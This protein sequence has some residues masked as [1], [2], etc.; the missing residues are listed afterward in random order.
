MFYGFEQILIEL[1]MA[2]RSVKPLHIRILL[3]LA[4]LDV[5]Q[6]DAV[7]VRPFHHLAADVLRAV[8]TAND[9]GSSSPFHDALVPG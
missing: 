2:C 9:F 7:F 4:G 5:V 1:L 6:L 3:G 8:I